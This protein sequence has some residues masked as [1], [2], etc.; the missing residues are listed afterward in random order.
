MTIRDGHPVSPGHTLLIPNRHVANWFDLTVVETTDLLAAAHHAKVALDS[1]IHPDAY[2]LGVNVGVAA[3][4]TV[5]TFTSIS[6]RGSSETAGIPAAAS[7]TAFPIAVT[8][9]RHV[10][11]S[12]RDARWHLLPGL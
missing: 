8:T 2:N 11:R 10:R 1:E 6:S 5:C 12:E 9:T 7:A 4:Q 3:G